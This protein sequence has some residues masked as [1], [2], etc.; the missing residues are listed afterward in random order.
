MLTGSMLAPG[1]GGMKAIEGMDRRLPVSIVRV[2]HTI[3]SSEAHTD[4]FLS[5]RR[6]LFNILTHTLP[7]LS[8]VI[9]PPSSRSS[10]TFSP[11]LNP[12]E[13]LVVGQIEHPDEEE[14][15]RGKNV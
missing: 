14:E 10:N 3:A 2:T 4:Y 11:N 5:S 8:T 13:R 12:R 1:F 7:A 9:I 15:V 6:A